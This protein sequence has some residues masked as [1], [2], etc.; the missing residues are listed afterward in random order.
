[1]EKGIW[2]KDLE[3]KTAP[4]RIKRL[5]EYTFSIVLTQGLNRQIRRMVKA[6]GNEIRFLKRTRVL[7]VNL[8]D[9]KPGEQ[10]TLSASQL[11][12]LYDAAYERR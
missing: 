12:E 11:K 9:M 2:L 10:R 7:T 3:V 8:E 1:M 6:V 5:G 4:C